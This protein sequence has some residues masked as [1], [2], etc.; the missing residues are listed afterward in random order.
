LGKALTKQS[1]LSRISSGLY[2]LLLLTALG[3]V[4]YSLG[5][6]IG[7]AE[8]AGE[9]I[10]SPPNQRA[11]EDP[12]DSKGESISP[13]DELPARSEELKTAK[14]VVAPPKIIQTP[15][16]LDSE[17]EGFQDYRATAYCLRGPTAT[18]LTPKSGMIAA[19]PRVLPFGT[20]VHIRAGSYTGVYKVVD[21]GSRIRGRIVDIYVSDRREAVKFGRRA[22]KL[23]VLGRATANSQKSIAAR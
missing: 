21:T 2:S 22:I 17:E 14:P 1:P 6:N 3:S 19:D 15:A 11:S 4:V 7:T 12:A 23:K 8:A 5:K 9:T 13:S 16:V 18:G 20:L 10:S